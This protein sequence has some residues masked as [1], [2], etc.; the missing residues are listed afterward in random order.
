MAELTVTTRAEPE[1]KLAKAVRRGV[2][3][4]FRLYALGSRFIFVFVLAQFLLPA[5]VG[6]YGLVA[7]TIAYVVYVLGMDMY[8][9]S[10][11]EIIA[12]DTSDWRKYITSHFT[13]LAVVAGVVLPLAL[14]VF[15][16]G[17]LPWE[18][19]GWFYLILVSEHVGYEIDRLLVALSRQMDASI[20]ILIRQA[21]L[22]T[23]MV[24][25]LLTVD[26]A[27]NLDL[28]FALWAGFNLVAIAVGAIFIARRTRIGRSS[29]QVDWRWVRRGLGISLPF[30]LGTLC[31]RFMFTA[32]RQVVGAVDGLEVLAAYT[33]AM[34]VANG[35][36]SVLS[37]AVHQ[38]AYPNLVKRH[39]EG[40]RAGFL[41]G[42]R[43][44]WIQ[45]IAIIAVITAGTLAAGDIVTGILKEPIYTKYWWLVPAAVIVLGI[46]NLSMV[47]HYGL[48]AMRG[49]RA[50]LVTTALSAFV[51]AGAAAA[52][53]A[54][55]Y[56]GVV[57]V[58]AG[59][60]AA[61]VW[62]LAGKYFGYR[63]LLLRHHKRG[64]PTEGSQIVAG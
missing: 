10:T 41:R 4:A 46:F 35:M 50:I 23:V 43:I 48:Y 39:A 1:V 29:F 11:R 34:T 61:S 45:T 38:F 57:A 37:V 60:A 55:G 22:P 53:L 5:D 8:T 56:A 51:F 9:Y 33:L 32:D 19:L 16:A 6:A 30:L 13:F 24:P 54:W 44:L 17:L 20:V 25:L 31:L 18:L 14:L 62:L 15:A 2:P 47:P 26:A 63:R 7:A 27:R 36:G 58:L 28:V 49:D 64:A 21:L 59:L 52:S 42:M 12:A 3:V 40:D